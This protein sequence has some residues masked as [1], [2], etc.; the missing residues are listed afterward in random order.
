MPILQSSSYN[1]PFWMINRHL[2]TIIPGIFRNVKVNVIP[3]SIIIPT[4]DNDVLEI[5]WYKT[6]GKKL[7]IISHG[8][9]GDSRRPYVLGLAKKFTQN[10]WD[11]MAW[12]F[13]G[14]G[15]DLNKTL[16]FYH[17]GASYDLDTVVKYGVQ[18]GF[19]DIA[20]SGVSLGGNVTL[21]YL[22]EPEVPNQVQS[23]AVFSV[24]LDLGS[25]SNEIAKPHNF[26][27]SSRFLKSLKLKIQRKIK[28]FPEEFDMNQIRSLK[29]IYDFDDKVTAPL[30]G[31]ECADDYYEKCS[32]INFIRK[33]KIPVL[34]VNA[35][36]DPFLSKSCFD[37]TNFN[38]SENVYF[39]MPKFGGH[40]GFSTY[41]NGSFYWS[42]DRA[43]EFI[44]QH[45]ECND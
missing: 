18:N 36:N 15:K 38:S 2:E 28:I 11:V 9:E 39:E 19:D 1:K 3:E 20:L 8:L 4:P 37:A 31:F 29:S 12:N 13:R 14:C 45:M 10:G 34:V 42:E 41:G 24:P 27:Y 25:T 43:L 33:I 23:A 6:K 44:S 5:D 21:K 16:K 30:H 32:S 40:V 7:V 22:G 17:S 35:L 26:L